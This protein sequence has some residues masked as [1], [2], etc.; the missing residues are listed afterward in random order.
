[1]SSP[2]IWVFFI[3]TSENSLFCIKAENFDLL[4]RIFSKLTT[5][6]IYEIYRFVKMTASV[7]VQEDIKMPKEYFLHCQ[8][9]FYN[10]P[11][12]IYHDGFV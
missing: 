1:M 8:Q 5:E 2:D 11:S 4:N 9:N 3:D 7:Y 10:T 6:L 12:D